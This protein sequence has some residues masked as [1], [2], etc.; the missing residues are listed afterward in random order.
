VVPAAALGL[1]A[2][3]VVELEL[4]PLVLAFVVAPVAFVVPRA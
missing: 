1:D 2:A 3:L 4:V